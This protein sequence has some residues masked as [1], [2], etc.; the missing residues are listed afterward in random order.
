MRYAEDAGIANVLA[1]IER[2][3]ERD[4]VFW[5]PAARLIE[6]ANAGSFS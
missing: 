4:P 2:F 6:A 1:R 3:A 5:Q